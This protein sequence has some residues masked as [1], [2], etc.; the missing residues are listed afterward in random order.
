MSRLT[1]F[2]RACS[3][4]GVINTLLY[5]WKTKIL[6]SIC[7]IKG[8]IGNSNRTGTLSTKQ[9]QH[10]VVFRYNSSDI[11]VFSQI[12]ISDEY[13]S[14]AILRDVK[15]IIDCG[16]NVGYSSAYFLSKFPEADVIAVE[17]DKRN[18]ELLNQ[19]L[20]AYG[21][22]VTTIWSAIWSHK[23]GLKVCIGQSGD[24]S[25]WATTVRECIENEL[26]DLEA[27]DI[28]TVLNQSNH[29]EI[30]IL[31]VDIE[32]SESIVFSRNFESWIN[33]VR[34]LVIELH[35]KECADIFYSALSSGSFS[36]SRS[37]EL[38]IAQ[39]R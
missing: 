18:Y 38:T 39:R 2:R 13:S 36:Y 30:D 6:N 33:K 20:S 5:I 25:E 32:G 26:P 1:N 12:F 14:L 23:V 4:V 17:P 21:N 34:L 28:A 10:P 29:D 31:K 9:L 19:D 27:V 11:S 15:L 22:R 24:E 8:K 37:G 7:G 35:G 3:N 16:A